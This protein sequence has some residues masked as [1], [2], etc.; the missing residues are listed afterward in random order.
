VNE[1]AHPGPVDAMS[2]SK[3]SSTT[4]TP[5]RVAEYVRMSTEHQQYSTLNQSAAI[6]DYAATHLMTVVRSYRDEGRSGLRLDGRDALQKLLSD[7]RAGGCGFE[8]VLVFDV[9]RWGRFQNGDEAA[10]H[11]FVCH[12]GGV[13]VIFV[14]EPFANDNSPLSSVL[15]G[16]KRAMAA[17]YS[18][19]L[20]GKVFAGQCRLIGLGYRQGGAAGYGLRRMRVDAQGQHLGILE[21]GQHKAHITDR[22]ILVPGPASEVAVVHGMYRDFVAG[23]GEAKIAKALNARGVLNAQGKPWRRHHVGMVLS[24]E[25]YAGDNIFG[26]TTSKLRQHRDINPEHQWIRRNA[27]FEP[28]ISPRLFARAKERFRQRARPVTDEDVLVPLKR[29]LV[30]EGRLSTLLIQKEPD[31]L[32][33]PALV[34]RFGGLRQIYSRLGFVADK[35]LSYVDVR[36]RLRGLRAEL[37]QQLTELLSSTGASVVGE[38]M[39]LCVDDAWTVSVTV[40]QASFYCDRIRWYVRQR[41]EN[42]DIV[43]FARMSGDGTAINDFVFAPRL[44]LEAPPRELS[45][46]GFPDVDGYIFP[47]LSVLAQLGDAHKVDSTKTAAQNDETDDVRGALAGVAEAC[48]RHMRHV[49]VALEALQAFPGEL[50]QTWD[51]AQEHQGIQQ[52]RDFTSPGEVV[53]RMIVLRGRITSL[54]ANAALVGWLARHH[55]LA[56]AAFQAAAELDGVRG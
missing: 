3:G 41:P 23:V 30:R 32:S 6:F 18:R 55:P 49:Q 48:R 14:N 13:R 29:I 25:K 22:V 20:S 56:L 40:V 38:G 34:R 24:N 52:L 27:S 35:N 28:V 5:I 33:I 51:R 15:K 54:M 45:P 2:R 21:R 42:S 46:K 17:E 10:Y 9:S 53:L 44:I 26:R 8:A 43:V 11:E 7:V 4:V 31:A 37:L 47:S 50:P 39:Q 1:A 12:L 19:E 36:Y 16:L